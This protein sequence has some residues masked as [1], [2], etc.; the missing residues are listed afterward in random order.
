M[1]TPDATETLLGRM[2]GVATGWWGALTGAWG[3]RGNAQEVSRDFYREIAES[4]YDYIWAGDLDGRIT[5]VNEA[6]ARILGMSPAALRGQSALAYI[7]DHPANP[8]FDAISARMLAG[9]TVPPLRV[10]WQTVQGPR[11]VEMA[12]SVI[13]APDGAPVGIRGISRDVQDRVEAEERLRE[14]EA[15]FRGL[16]ESEMAMFIRFDLEGNVAYANDQ[17]CRTLGVAREEFVGSPLFVTVHEDDR[18]QLRALMEAHR[19]GL[20][21]AHSEHRLRT[22]EGWR[23]T[24]WEGYALRD[25]HGRVVEIQAVGHDIDERKQTERALRASEA[26]YRGLVESQE[27]VVVRLDASGRVTFANEACERKFGIPRARISG[28]PLPLI[29]EEDL[30][31]VVGAL[32][33]I[34]AAPHRGRVQCREMTPDGWRW[35]EW[36]AVAIFEEDALT[37]IQAVGRDV[38]ERRAAEDALQR[39]LDDLRRSQDQ[40]R[41]LAQRQVT[42]RDQE[43]KRL[44]FDLHDDVC[45]ELVG[46]GIMLG[47]LRQQIGPMA[48]APASQF[49]RIS[50]YLEQVVDHLRLL[51]REMQPLQLRDL[52]LEGSLRSLAQGMSSDTCTV[53]AA[54]ATAV[55]CLAEE[56]EVGIYRIAQEALSNAVRHAEARAIIVRLAV[57]GG[58]LRLEVADDGQGFDPA[59]TTNALGLVSMEERAL[60]LGG[61]LTV[62]SAPGKGTMLRL[63]CPL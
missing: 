38:T 43:R 19:N 58:T 60:S 53:D 12:P 34:R 5:Y 28:E 6:G 10:Q 44:G 57:D 39:S 50:G 33:A 22:P 13:R 42:A 56:V 9:E 17:M 14:S 36:D 35:F 54:V 31:A 4:A 29:H 41:S 24:E 40:L 59:S 8:R 63:E 48:T 15:G 3:V 7:T 25:A 37:E 11:W 62:H 49:D 2:W 61:Q 26:R 55:P 21:R 30:P 16:V 51:A 45:Q 20:I 47:S 52:G 18:A 46:I 1:D 27:E 32:E 23:W